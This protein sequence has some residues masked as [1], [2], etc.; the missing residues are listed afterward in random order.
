[1]AIYES[2]EVISGRFDKK[3]IMDQLKKMNI[4]YFNGAKKEKLAEQLF[5][6]TGGDPSKVVEEVKQPSENG[7][8]KWEKLGEKI[9]ADVSKIQKGKSD[10]KMK[11][12]IAENYNFNLSP[13]AVNKQGIKVRYV[14]GLPTLNIERQKEITDEFPQEYIHFRGVDGHVFEM[15]KFRGRS[16]FQTRDPLLQEFIEGLQGYGKRFMLYDKEEVTR[17]KLADKRKITLLEAEV[18]KAER[19]DL[20]CTLCFLDMKAG[21]N[22]YDSLKN[23]SDT[24]KLVEQSL[25]YIE[26]DAD[27]FLNAMSS[28]NARFV[29]LVHLAKDKGIISVSSDGREIKGAN[30]NLIMTSS[31]ATNWEDDLASYVSQPEGQ[32]LAAQMEK[33]TGWYV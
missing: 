24:N 2:P 16:V 13:L 10:N 7:A 30:G 22:T 29:H 23:E 20:I 1:M 15:G 3:E 14:F 12:Y 11:T 25:N 33:V 4:S 8:S 26:K 6:A 9:K 17:K 31:V 21:R 27:A 28:K 5:E 32:Q 19:D 18:F